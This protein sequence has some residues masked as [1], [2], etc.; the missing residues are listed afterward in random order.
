MGIANLIVRACRYQKLVQMIWIRLDRL[1]GFMMV[2]R[3]PSLQSAT[4]VRISSLPTAPFGERSDGRQIIPGRQ[5]VY[6]R[7][8]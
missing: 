7:Q 1:P 8:P 3:E 5:D 4:N 6:K 2:E